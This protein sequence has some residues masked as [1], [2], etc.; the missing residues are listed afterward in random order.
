MWVYRSDD[1]NVRILRGAS[2]VAAV[3][4]AALCSITAL[5]G[6]SQ[7][8]FEWVDAPTRYAAALVRDGGWLRA[9]I[10]VDDLFIAA[11]TIATIYLAATLAQ[12][13]FRVEHALVIMGGVGA[14]LLDLSENHQLLGLLRFAEQTV[15]IEAQTI[16]ARSDASQL[17]WLV[18][19][20]TFVLVGLSLPRGGEL[21]RRMLAWSLV[22]FQL[23]IG[24]LVW[25][26]SQPELR[27]GLVWARY[28]SFLVGFVVISLLAPRIAGDAGE[29]GAPA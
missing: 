6:V 5:T 21:P 15:A 7:Q 11:Y 18:G 28:A 2:G 8:R 16:L 27:E 14:G 24:A 25:T 10:A 17:K 13:R 1:D 29:T 19:H 22:W 9:I 23:P 20:L 3:L 26:V 4:L 12:R